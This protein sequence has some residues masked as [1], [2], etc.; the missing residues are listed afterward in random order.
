MMGMRQRVHELAVRCGVSAWQAFLNFY[1]SDNLTY[2]AS[3]AYYALLSLFPLVM[4]TLAV[5]GWATGDVESR[6]AVIEFLLRFFPSRFDFI[7][8]QLDALRA[9]GWNVGVAGSI[10]LVW[11]GL[12]IFGMITTAINYAWGVERTPNF[13]Q[14]KLISAIMLLISGIILLTALLLVSASKIAGSLWIGGVLGHAPALAF[15]TSV[16]VRYATTLLFIGVI[17]LLYRYVPNDT[18]VSF[19]DVWLGAVVTGLLWR[20]TLEVFSWYVEG[21]ASQLTRINGSIAIVVMFLVWVYMQ[22]V[23]FLYGVEFTAVYARL[24][25]EPTLPLDANDN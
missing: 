13:W 19:A 5:L 10:G 11:G 16:A 15:L 14:H 23:I 22:A 20:A 18:S 9:G 6:N 25:H 1:S 8:S 7:T 17:L 24:R 4:L 3:M 2:A 21:R 12:A